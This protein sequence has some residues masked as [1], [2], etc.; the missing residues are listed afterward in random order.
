[1]QAK[2]LSYLCA[3]L[4]LLASSCALL[5]CVALADQ[6]TIAVG[7]GFAVLDNN[8]QV[9]HLWGNDYYDF[10]QIAYGWEKTLSGTFNLLLEP[11]AAYVNRP[12]TGLDLGFTVNGRYYFGPTNHRGFFATVGAGGAYTTIKFEEQ[13]THDL[14]VLHGGLGYKWEKLFVEARFRHYS[15]GGFSHPNRSVDTALVSVGRAF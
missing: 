9:G 7:Y 5:P 14:F 2:T 13:G 15:N 1:M 3:L 11:Y 10:G 12:E 4:L 6:Q 8:R